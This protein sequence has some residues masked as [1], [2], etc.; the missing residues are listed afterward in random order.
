MPRTKGSKNKKVSVPVKPVAE[1]KSPEPAT[2]TYQETAVAEIPKVVTF[3]GKTVVEVTQDG[4]E[5]LTHF[6]CRMSD[7]TTMHVPKALFE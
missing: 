7:G 2:I 1:E 3:E 6:H 5:T 4:K